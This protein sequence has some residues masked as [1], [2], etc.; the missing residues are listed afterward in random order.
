[1]AEK[2]PA[3]CSAAENGGRYVPK[4]LNLIGGWGNP[5]DGARERIDGDMEIGNG[6]GN[7][8]IYYRVN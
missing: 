1:M 3:I 2:R 7:G 5:G 8:K 4:R 6:G